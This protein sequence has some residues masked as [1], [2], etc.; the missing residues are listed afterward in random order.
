MGS[1]SGG[2]VEGAVVLEAI[3]ALADG[4]P[5][6]LTYGVADDTAFEVGLGLRWHH[7]HYGRTDWPGRA[8]AATRACW[9]IW[10]PPAPR[11]DPWRC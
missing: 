2:C 5:R 4:R 7:P 8:R 3:E 6:V 11:A 9:P 1:V 10:S